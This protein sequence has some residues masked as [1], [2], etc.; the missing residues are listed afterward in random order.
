M[1]RRM[2]LMIW[3][4][5]STIHKA[6]SKVLSGSCG[7]KGKMLISLCLLDMNPITEFHV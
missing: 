3:T 7:D 6:M 5:N 1:R 4:T 2:E